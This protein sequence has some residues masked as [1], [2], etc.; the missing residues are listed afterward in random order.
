MPKPASELFRDRIETTVA[1]LLREMRVDGGG[2]AASLDADSD[3]E[4]GSYYTWDQ[5][6]DRMPCSVDDAATFLS[7]YTLAAPH[8]WEGKPIM[9]RSNAVSQ[10][11]R[12]A[13]KPL[14]AKLFEA[15]E[16]RVRPG[17]TTRC[18][19]TGTAW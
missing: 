19:P 1:W 8:G 5:C 16:K 10:P 7:A 3:G 15:R 11:S 18:W 9:H 4:E 14:L 2:F 13:I 17:A 12:D 6:R